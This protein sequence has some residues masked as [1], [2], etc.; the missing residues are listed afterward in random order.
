MGTKS[1]FFRAFVAG[2]TI[3][4]GR[5]ITP[6]MIDQIVETF[7]VDTYT[8]GINIEHLTG[9]SPQPPFNRYGDVIA[10]K[11]QTDDVT[12]DGKV[13]KRRALYAQVD[14]LDQLVGLAQSGQ[15]PFPSVELTPSYSG[16][17]KIGLVGLAFTDNPAS[18]ATQKLTFSRSAAVHG[19]IYSTG[20]EAVE[21]QFDGKPAEAGGIAAAIEAGFAKIASK[22]TTK[23]EEP[24]K[25]EQKTPANDNGFDVNAFA[26]D[27]GGVI[28]GEIAAAVKPAADAV[29]SLDARFTAFEAK[30]QQTPA[31][32]FSRAPA[33]GGNVAMVTDC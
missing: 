14:A 23:V 24:K 21:L 9:F 10:V 11:A 1:K 18:I 26:K 17:G 8:P 28:A 5:E 31:P 33:S 20:A 29:A 25:D 7:N 3:S 4:D 15:K 16:T 30:L 2:Q 27:F 32:G 6:E 13:E 12:I 19:T 22:F